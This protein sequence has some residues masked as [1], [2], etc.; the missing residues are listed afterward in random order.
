[1]SV[2]NNGGVAIV[3]DEVQLVRTSELLF[4]KRGVPMTFAAYDGEEAIEKL[5]KLTLSPG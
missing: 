2:E 5:K 3:D 1:L 4:K